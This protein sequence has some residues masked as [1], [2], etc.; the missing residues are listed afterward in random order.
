MSAAITDLP[1]AKLRL[2]Q[3]KEQKAKISAEITELAAAIANA[4]SKF[5]VGEVITW[6]AGRSR[7]KG[8]IFEVR[9][10][11]GSSLEYHVASIR[12]D[13]TEGS[14]ARVLDWPSGDIQLAEPPP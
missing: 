10:W 9:P 6:N 13:G 5:K 2:E 14:Q 11:C 8:R 1:A 3:L 12:A 4:E 7:R